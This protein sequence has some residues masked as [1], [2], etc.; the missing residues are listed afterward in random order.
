M[1]KKKTAQR[2]RSL[3]IGIILGGKIVEERLL[4]K[5]Q[6][7]TIGQSVKNLFSIPIEGMPRQWQLFVF[8]EGRWFLRIN[9]RMDGRI[10]SGTHVLTLSQAKAE[11]SKKRG[12]C[13][14]IPLEKNARGKIVLGELSLLFQFVMAPPPQPRPHLPA[15]VRNSTLEQIDPLMSLC[16]LVS[17]FFF[18]GSYYYY[19][20]QPEKY[21]ASLV[22]QVGQEIEQEMF[23]LQEAQELELEVEEAPKATK[24]KKTAKKPSKASEGKKT[25]N[26]PKK[27]AGGKKKTGFDSGAAKRFALGIGNLNDT[28]G[29]A[30]GGPGM[31]RDSGRDTQKLM[32]D[33]RKN[34]KA[35]GVG[36]G[37]RRAGPKGGGGGAVASRSGAGTKGAGTGSGT[38]ASGPAKV[39]R[40]STR[41]GS[42]LKGDGRFRPNIS[43]Y[44]N[45]ITRCV[46]QQLKVVPSVRGKVM[47]K[48]RVNSQG[49]VIQAKATGSTGVE[50]CIQSK[51]KSFVFIP[52][53]KESTTVVFP[54]QLSSS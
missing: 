40:V 8:H 51:A 21:V 12:D 46:N 38:K 41:R 54:L 10:S 50:K 3:R 1:A 18:G 33:A 14:L 17:L 5:L 29:P 30:A 48:L 22:E 31:D 52:P 49:R 43:R 42:T 15:S 6:P 34:G 11:K 32:N 39:G 13:W 19:Y 27:A 26:K 37:G 2:Q 25:A 47:L 53:P 20:T 45:A 35:V 4:R 16:L 36:G 9:E 28:G 23:T 24:T 44:K 7:V